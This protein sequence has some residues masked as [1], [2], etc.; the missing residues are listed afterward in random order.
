MVDLILCWL[1]LFNWLVNRVYSLNFKNCILYI[2]KLVY[3]IKIY[4]CG[5]IQIEMF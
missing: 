3:V 2:I 5:K 1:R 4:K